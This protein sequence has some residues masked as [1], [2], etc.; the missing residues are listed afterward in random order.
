MET[1]RH[2]PLYKRLIL[3]ILLVAGLECEAQDNPLTRNFEEEN[4][5][6]AIPIDSS[7][8]MFASEQ[9]QIRGFESGGDWKFSF[10]SGF[11]HDSNPF[12]S[13]TPV[14]DW[15]WTY[16]FDLGYEF[17]IKELE[18]VVTPSAVIGGN[19]YDESDVLDGDKTSFGL[20]TTWVEAIFNPTLRYDSFW[21]F[22][23]GFGKTTFT[24][25]RFSFALGDSTT[26][27][28]LA[29]KIRG[30]GG[31]S[32]SVAESETE[33]KLFWSLGMGYGL[34]DIEDLNNWFSNGRVGIA[35]PISEKLE[36]SLTNA[37]AFKA[38]DDFQSLD[39][40]VLTFNPSARLVYEICKETLVGIEVSYVN[41]EDTIATRDFDQV[42]TNVFVKYHPDLNGFFHRAI[43][44]PPVYGGY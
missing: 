20:S 41:A 36:F 17:W 24:E 40:D 28:E 10:S 27:N 14:D 8:P 5:R 44:L 43:G 31:K 29:K 4:S 42:T 19:R 3:P 26:F 37:L 2:L 23:S 34:S 30:E 1:A 22:E 35:L 21:G 32:A 7:A 12:R 9:D 33:V 13:T 18:M 25:S 15:N 38:F 16:G 6:S 11:G 39:R